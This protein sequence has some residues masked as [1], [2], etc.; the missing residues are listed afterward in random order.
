MTQRR[1][2]RSRSPSTK[3]FSVYWRIKYIRYYLNIVV[4]GDAGRARSF[5]YSFV[6]DVEEKVVNKVRE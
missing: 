2:T 5:S 6:V 4:N 3:L 1:L